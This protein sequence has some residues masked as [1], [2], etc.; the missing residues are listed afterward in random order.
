MTVPRAAVRGRHRRRVCRRPRAAQHIGLVVGRHAREQ[1]GQMPGVLLVERAVRAQVRKGRIRQC[2]R[3]AGCDRPPA[4]PG[5][6]WCLRERKPCRRSRG[7][8]AVEQVVG[9]GDHDFGRQIRLAVAHGVAS[10]PA[11]AM[12]LRIHSSWPISSSMYSATARRSHARRSG[13]RRRASSAAASCGARGGRP[14]PG[15]PGSW[16]LLTRPCR[17]SAMTGAASRCARSAAV[18]AISCS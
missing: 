17:Q 6:R 8:A 3:L 16:R 13:R 18:A 7:I 9:V 15:R 4:G 11:A 1:I 10:P 2:Q 12:S 5:R 14:A